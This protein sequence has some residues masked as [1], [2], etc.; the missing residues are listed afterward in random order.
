MIILFLDLQKEFPTLESQIQLKDL[1]ENDSM[2]QHMRKNFRYCL[3]LR[4]LKIVK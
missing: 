4:L 1:I 2:R 3:S